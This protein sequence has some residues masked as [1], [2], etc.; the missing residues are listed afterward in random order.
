MS[1]SKVP[2]S[3]IFSIFCNFICLYWHS[4]F[5]IILYGGLTAG[6]IS[7]ASVP[8]LLNLIVYSLPL[9][10]FSTVISSLSHTSSL[11]RTLKTPEEGRELVNEPSAENLNWHSTSLIS[12]SQ[13]K[14]LLMS[15]VLS[16]FL[17]V[18]GPNYWGDF[19]INTIPYFNSLLK[20]N[21]PWLL[22]N[23][24]KFESNSKSSFNLETSYAYFSSG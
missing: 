13:W 5:I 3:T 1:Y 9:S 4:R 18:I 12:F 17:L 15:L 7:V 19:S 23:S 8:A 6:M 20:S 10:S 22:V 2:N 21:A 16:S 14:E 11:V 24:T